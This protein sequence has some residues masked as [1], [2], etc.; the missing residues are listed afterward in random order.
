M[1]TQLK[2][3]FLALLLF[4]ATGISAQN[5]TVTPSGVKANTEGFEMEIQFMSPAIVR[6]VKFPEGSTP[7]NHA[8]DALARN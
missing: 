6:V 5:Y 2:H 1:K 4:F 8:H 7:D 3:I